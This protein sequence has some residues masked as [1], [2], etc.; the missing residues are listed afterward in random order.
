MAVYQPTVTVGD[1][2]GGF[3]TE[4]IWLIK[5]VGTFLGMIILHLGFKIAVN[6]IKSRS[7]HS[8]KEYLEFIILKPAYF[9]IWT[10][11]TIYIIGAF[12]EKFGLEKILEYLHPLKK[13]LLVIAISWVFFRWKKILEIYLTRGHFKKKIDSITISFIEK[14]VSVVIVF[15]SCLIILQVLGL[16]IVPLIAFGGVGAAAVGFAAKDVIANFFG[17]LMIYITRPFKIGDFLE[18]P[19]E[20]IS[21]VVE[22]I[23][24]YLTSIRNLEKQPI[25]VP[26]AMFS[27]AQILNSS[28]RTHRKI[29]ENIGIRYEDFDKLQKILGEIRDFIKSEKQIDQKQ[30]SLV[31]FDSFKEYSLNILIKTYICEDMDNPDSFFGKKQAIL[32]KIHE[33]ISNNGAE[34]PFPTKTTVFNK[35]TN[36]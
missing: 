19:K 3:L 26:N 27:T 28:R 23:G 32:M 17:G 22:H 7:K 12:S 20:K 24:W 15:I 31:C 16:D 13:V 30:S 8:W 1:E 11:G 2:I 29:E 21:G 34:I 6:I 36:V 14:I 18:M 4:N 5:I 9:C 10:I 33:I 35:K 25:Y